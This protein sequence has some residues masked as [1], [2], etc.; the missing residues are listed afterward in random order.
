MLCNI[1]PVASFRRRGEG[2]IL[3][4]TG[5]VMQ[6][7]R[8]ADSKIWRMDLWSWVSVIVVLDFWYLCLYLYLRR[9][10]YW[11]EFFF[12]IQKAHAI[13]DGQYWPYWWLETLQNNYICWR[14]IYDFDLIVNCDRLISDSLTVWYLYVLVAIEV[15]VLALELEYL[16]LYCRDRLRLHVGGQRIVGVFKVAR[17][18]RATGD[19]H[20]LHFYGLSWETMECGVRAAAS[21]ISCRYRSLGRREL[22]CQMLLVSVPCQWWDKW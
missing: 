11:Q 16:Y 8:V 20:G 14:L 1:L 7:E 13:T 6:P 2:A 21:Y 12:W 4:S 9:S 3:A 5:T 18:R 19:E 22:S 15:R 10:N 17:R